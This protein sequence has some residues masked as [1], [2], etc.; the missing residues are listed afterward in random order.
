M[1]RKRSPPEQDPVPPAQ[2]AAVVQFWRDA[3]PARWFAKDAAFDRA[4]RER[5]HDL[6]FAAA[7][8]RCDAWVATAEGALALLLLLDQYP[9]NSFRGTG[10]MYATD[11]LARMFCRQA[12]DAGLDRQVPQD[13]RLFFYLPLSHSEDMPDQQRALALNRALG[14][15]FASHAQGHL[16]I[17]ARF[18]RFP[19]RNAMLGRETT[20]AEQAFLAEGGFAG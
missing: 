12:L 4:F 6:H 1:P 10:H 7:A 2:A 9:R 3:G 11:P 5:F 19:H 15:P 17:V 13:L 16:D 14:E 20:A 8:R 18:G